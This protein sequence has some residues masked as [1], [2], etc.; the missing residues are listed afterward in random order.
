MKAEGGRRKAGGRRLVRLAALLGAVALPLTVRALDFQLH[1]LK[2]EEDGLT[3]ERSY[4]S[5]DEHTRVMIDLPHGWSIS[6]G[7][8]FLSATPQELA[9]SILRIEK[10]PLTPDTPFRDKGLDVYRQRLLAAV[11]REAVNVRMV[12]EQAD[13]LPVFR[14]KDYE[15]IVEYDY[16]G[17]SF[18]RGAMFVNLN[19]RE[20]ILLTTVAR[21]DHFDAVHEAG[22]NVLRSWNPVPAP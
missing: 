7:P 17:Q 18:R 13:P 10:S 15:W 1:S 20:Q 21:R 22:L 9:D 12:Q 14:W 11:P 4:F 5:G 3:Y 8:G 19:A 16:F 2:V 6:D